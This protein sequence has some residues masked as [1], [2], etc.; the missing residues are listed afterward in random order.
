MFVQYGAMKLE[1]YLRLHGVTAS[2][3]AEKCTVS[4]STIT[5][6]ARGETIPTMEV[7][8]RIADNTGG[9]VKPNDFM[10]MV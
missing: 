3:L 5:R 9:R 6:A 10:E 8:R 4:V 2:A 1:T 7:M